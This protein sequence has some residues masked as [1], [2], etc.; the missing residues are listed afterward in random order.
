MDVLVQGKKRPPTI[1]FHFLDVDQIWSAYISLRHAFA[2][3]ERL[4]GEDG[5]VHSL[6]R[7][8][9]LPIQVKAR[10]RTPDTNTFERAGIAS[11]SCSVQTLDA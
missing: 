9:P 3:Q 8:F 4:D 6:G 5:G 10:Q 1:Y 7:P 11:S 2:S